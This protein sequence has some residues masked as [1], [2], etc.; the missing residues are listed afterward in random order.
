MKKLVYISILITASVLSVIAQSPCPTI[1]VTGPTSP[2]PIGDSMTF[3]AKIEGIEFEKIKFEWTVDKGTI[4]S[5]QGTSTITVATNAD[6][7]GQTITA[8]VKISGLPQ[9]CL[10]E[11]YGVGEITPPPPVCGLPRVIDDYGKL[12]WQ[13]EKARLESVVVELAND[14]DVVAYFVVQ[15]KEKARFRALKIREEKIKKF[16]F[17]KH[18]IAKNRLIFV[19]AGSGESNTRI[20][21]I[22]KGVDFP[23]S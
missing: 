4:T 18:K 22:P 11:A 1:S 23:V 12:S 8:A 10:N 17:E 16:L 9:N 7:A 19:D 13:D 20:Y 14:K 2:T 6:I 3:T 5:G 21:I 15:T